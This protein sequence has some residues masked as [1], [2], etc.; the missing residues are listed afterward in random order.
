MPD[1]VIQRVANQFD[2]EPTPPIIVF[3][4]VVILGTVALLWL[5]S[6]RQPNVVKHYLLIAF[7]IAIFEVF[8]APMWNNVKL[9]VWAYIYKDVSWVLTVGWSSLVIGTIFLV[10]RWLPWARAWQRFLIYIG[11]LTALT[12]IAESVVI[13]LGIRS[14]APEVMA[15]VIGSIIPGTSISLHLLYYVPVFMSLVICFYKY[16]AP[17]LDGEPMPEPADVNWLRSLAIGL[18]GVFAFEIM[19][20]PLVDNRGFP[21]WSYV[22]RD[23]SVV[24]TGFWLLL[25]WLVT[26]L[27]N[28]LM[29]RLGGLYRFFLSLVVLCIVASPIEAWMVRQGYR[30]YGPSATENFSGLRTL[31]GDVPVEVIF[32]V[33]LYLALVICFIRYWERM[34]AADLQLGIPTALADMPN[35]DL[36]PP[37]V[38][39]LD[40]VEADV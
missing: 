14:Y 3:E 5:L 2:K 20:E 34:T 15:V 10:D 39:R 40:A 33:P 6:R 7:G 23:I 31:I 16:W 11:V 19:I 38:T 37:S 22:Y 26:N 29:P 9:G 17:L 27:V 1:D 21:S 36:G 32:A 4:L 12:A 18:V 28:R 25:I 24:M 35:G 13:A 8:T 30:V